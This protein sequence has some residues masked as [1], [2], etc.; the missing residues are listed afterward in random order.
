MMDNAFRYVIKN[1]INNS[2]GYPYKGVAGACNLNKVTI[3][4]FNITSIVDVSSNSSNC[5]TALS[6]GLLN[7]P[8]SIAIDATNWQYYSSGIF[9]NCSSTISLNHGVLLVGFNNTSSSSS[10]WKIKNSWG[11]GWGELGYMRL[12]YNYMCGIGLAS[13]PYK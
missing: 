11:I 6:A 4:F 2:V 9:S 12:N 10:Y 8:L 7:A 5:V 3:Q 13:Y 1:G